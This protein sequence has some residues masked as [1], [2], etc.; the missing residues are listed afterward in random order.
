MAPRDGLLLGS[1]LRCNPVRGVASVFSRPSIPSAALFVALPTTAFLAETAEI[2]I[3]DSLQC[4]ISLSGEIT[5]GTT[6]GLRE[7]LGILIRH[8]DW[9]SIDD[10][11]TVSWRTEDWPLC[12]DSPGG[13]LDEKARLAEYLVGTGIGR[14][15]MADA[16]CLS[17]RALIFMLGHAHHYAAHGSVNRRM[18]FTARLGGYALSGAVAKILRLSNT[19]IAGQP[20]AIAPVL[21]QE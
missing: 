15:L 12:P 13:S 7:H 1:L 17:A 3:A 5:D 6:E 14:A 8:G 4:R 2:R 19:Q 16:A 20:S 9:G 21:A 18:H 11:Q 10:T